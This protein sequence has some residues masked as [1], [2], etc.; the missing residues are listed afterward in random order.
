MEPAK[1]P[2]SITVLQ[3]YPHY[4]KLKNRL[5][6][7]NAAMFQKYRNV[8]L[9]VFLLKEIK[10]IRYFEKVKIFYPD[11]VLR[12]ARSIIKQLNTVF[13]CT[14]QLVQ[15]EYVVMNS[16]S[17]HLTELVNYFFIHKF[18]QLTVLL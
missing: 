11:L 12:S 8:S 16:L 2:G 17:G 14:S 6:I 18:E 10:L 5:R 1:D 9:Y 7:E 3:I 15:F 4:T 13:W